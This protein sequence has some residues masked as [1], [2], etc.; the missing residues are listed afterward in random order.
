MILIEP[1]YFCTY[2]CQSIFNILHVL[3]GKFIFKEN[4]L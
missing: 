4:D 3:N 2:E 1:C